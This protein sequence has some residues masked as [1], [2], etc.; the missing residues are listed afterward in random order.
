MDTIFWPT[1]TGHSVEVMVALSGGW[2]QSNDGE[3]GLGLG[4]CDRVLA[5]HQPLREE[6]QDG[7]L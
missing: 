6:R 1:R 3:S 7:I 5:Y 4:P 2:R